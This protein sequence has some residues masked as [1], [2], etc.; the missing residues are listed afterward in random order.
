MEASLINLIFIPETH[1]G[2]QE[3]EEMDI[4]EWVDEIFLD[5][6][7]DAEE[8]NREGV[9]PK[10]GHNDNSENHTFNER[11]IVEGFKM[12][13]QIFQEAVEENDYLLVFTS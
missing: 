13:K 3:T 6:G 5:K 9:Y 2:P 4:N 10:I 12:F 7:Y 1:L 11:D 8:M